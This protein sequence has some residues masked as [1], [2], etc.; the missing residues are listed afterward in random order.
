MRELKMTEEVMVRIYPDGRVARRDAAAFLGLRP[1][2][3][4][5]WICTGYGPRALRVGNR[6]FYR[7][8]DLQAFV[9][10]GAREDSAL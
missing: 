7:F 2:T 3:L 4:A 1:K 6:V 5:N 9:A 8:A 10:T